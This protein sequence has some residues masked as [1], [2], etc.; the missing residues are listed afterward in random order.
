MP[1]LR[2]PLAVAVALVSIWVS[3]SVAL[4]APLWGTPDVLASDSS[5][6]PAVAVAVDSTKRS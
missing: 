2:V 5:I 6:G 1:A 4:I 3:N